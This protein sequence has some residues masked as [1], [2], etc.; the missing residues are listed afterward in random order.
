MKPPFFYIR[1]T[2]S[3]RIDSGRL[4]YGLNIRCCRENLNIILFDVWCGAVLK[5]LQDPP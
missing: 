3:L 1:I 5:L 2:R 4:E